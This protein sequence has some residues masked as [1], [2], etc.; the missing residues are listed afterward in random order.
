MFDALKS[1]LS[2][3]SSGDKVPAMFDDNDH[4]LAAAALL[5]HSAAIDGR[6]ADV[7]RAKLHALLKQRY[8]L[9]DDATAAL[10]E[11]ATEA[12]Q[13][14]VDVYHFTRILLRSL[15][16]TGRVRIVEM[17]W[18]MAYADGHVTEFEDNLIWRTAD[19]LGVSSH[20]RIA[21]RRRVAD[22][23]KPVQA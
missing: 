11:Q 10:I 2:D 7:E 1:F 14:A 16:E 9:D 20:E 19:L 17:M 23:A 3:L 22:E 21:L 15:D 18:E 12:E 4:R 5:I 13:E 8:S 6:I